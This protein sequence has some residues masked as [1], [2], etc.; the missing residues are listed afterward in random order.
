MLLFQVNEGSMSHAEVG[1]FKVSGH[2][3]AGT[4][5]IHFAFCFSTMKK[6]IIVRADDSDVFILWLH[7]QLYMSTSTTISMDM[8]FSSKKQQNVSHVRNCSLT[9]PEGRFRFHVQV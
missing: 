8:G 6:V 4:M 2:C 5:M 7:Q 1:K 9:W 3:E